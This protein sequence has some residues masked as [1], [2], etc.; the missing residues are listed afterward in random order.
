M[1]FQDPFSSLNPVR[2]VGWIL[3]E[4]LKIQGGHS[5]GER[6]ALVDEVLTRLALGRS[7]RGGCPGSFPADSGREYLL[8][9]LLSPGQSSLWPMNR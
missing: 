6:K 4:A 1:I 9:R 2:P 5:S 7:I 3:E 8:L